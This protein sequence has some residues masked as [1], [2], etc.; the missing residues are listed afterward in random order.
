MPSYHKIIK[1]SGVLMKA[2][3]LLT[4]LYIGV[5]LFG[6]SN[7]VLA[8][9]NTAPSQSIAL[10][11]SPK[12]KPGFKYFDY[13]SPE[14]KKGGSVTLSELGNFDSLNPIIAK[15]T[16]ESNIGLT[17]DSLMVGS[18]DEPFSRYGLV[19]KTIEIADNGFSVIFTLNPQA[20]FH[21]GSPILAKDIKFS[22]DALI[23]IGSPV[24]RTIY[25]DVD[26]TQVLSPRKIKFKLKNNHN[27]E[28]PLTLGDFAIFSA[29]SFKNNIQALNKTYLEAPLSSGPYRVK[30]LEPGRF[31]EYQRVKNYWAKNHP[32]RKNLYNFDQL[33]YDYYRDMTVML[34]ALKAGQSDYRLE[35]VAKQW[36]NG[37]TGP[38]VE[39]GK[40]KRLEQKFASPNGM[41]AFVMNIRRPPFNDLAFR[42][43]MNLAFDFEWANSN[44]FYNAYQRTQSFFSNSELAATGLPSA[45]ELAIM[46]PYKKQLPKTVFEEAYKAPESDG[47]G[48]NRQNL[49]KAK[50]LLDATGYVYKQGQLH[51]AD[52]TPIAIE[53]IIRQPGFERIIN[54]YIKAL[55]RLGIKAD[56]RILET[57]QYIN[58]LRSFDFDV[59]VHSFP[60]SLSP[61]NE[62]IDYWHSSQADVKSSRNL[63]GI[64]HQVIDA[65][66]EQIIKAESR[67]HLVNL[68]KVLDRVLLSQHYVIPQWHINVNRLAFWDKFSMPAVAPVYDKYHSTGFWTWWIDAQKAQALKQ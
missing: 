37:Y 45:Q 63:I 17:F 58:R 12:Y 16:V 53:F 21:D 25:K 8:R 66:T 31:I 18:A 24:Y 61:G 11:G 13:T 44:F 32:V 56:L 34:E 3:K 10:F 4:P 65:L 67:E 30:A 51:Q 41:Q 55:K 47:K 33:H 68:S 52:G 27:K 40:I 19:A 54:P 20:K 39:Q 5:L 59:I 43:A 49:I 15:G 23:Q 9:L 50:K 26:S 14:A 28:L 2:A 29:K 1:Q 38:A 60:Q 57:S 48:F 62:Q 35:Y 7:S 64:K 6:I 46:E 42:K 36:A 22:F